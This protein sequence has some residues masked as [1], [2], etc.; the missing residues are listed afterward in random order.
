MSEEDSKRC[1]LIKNKI[2]G[3]LANMS[4][5]LDYIWAFSQ[6]LEWRILSKE[7]NIAWNHNSFLFPNYMYRKIPIKLKN[8]KQ[9][10]HGTLHSVQYVSTWAQKERPVSN[11]RKTER[12]NIVSHLFILLTARK[13]ITVTLGNLCKGLCGSISKE[14]KKEGAEIEFT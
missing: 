12:E 5:Y 9:F 11:M 1:C 6:G 2:K 7:K 4:V 14:C 13:V 10:S 3:N 8:K